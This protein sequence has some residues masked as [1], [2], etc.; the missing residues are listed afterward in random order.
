MN[1]LDITRIFFKAVSGLVLASSLAA[2]APVLM[3]GAVVTGLVAVDRRT[4]GAQLEDET[5]E[6][7]GMT[8]LRENLGDRVHVNLTSYNRRALLTGEVPN[9]QDRQLVEKLVSGLP[10]VKI[11]RAHV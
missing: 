6:L 11:G 2:C 8:T 9:A 3:G 7:K 4:P 10:N 1:K 5:I